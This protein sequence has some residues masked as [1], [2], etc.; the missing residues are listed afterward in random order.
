M[1]QA[2][3]KSRSCKLILASILLGACIGAFDITRPLTE[4]A[5]AQSQCPAS[6]A[7]CVLTGCSVINGRGCCVYRDVYGTGVCPSC[8]SCPNWTGGGDVG[9]E[10]PAFP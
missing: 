8:I 10:Q 5:S 3:L 1:L 9:P 2:A 6:G 7:Q 4:T